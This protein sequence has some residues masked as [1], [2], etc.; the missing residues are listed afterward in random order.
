VL[1]GVFRA[2]A[3]LGMTQSAFF[4]YKSL[5]GAFQRDYGER[6]LTGLMANR[7]YHRFGLFSILSTG[8]ASHPKIKVFSL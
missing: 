7:Q 3:A 5:L 6:I 1:Q 2:L 8:C 4:V